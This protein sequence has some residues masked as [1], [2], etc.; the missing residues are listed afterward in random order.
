MVSGFGLACWA[1]LVPLAKQ[2][3]AIGDGAL[4]LLLLC[5]GLGSVGAMQLAGPL[6]SK[7]GARPAILVG[8]IGQAILL[9]FLAFAPTVP[10]MAIALLLFGAFLGVI[11]VGMNVHAVEV[12]KQAGKPLMSGFHGLFSVGGFV[13]S[14]LLTAVLSLRVSP[15]IGAVAASVLMIATLALAAPRLI[16]TPQDRG[17][18]ADRNPARDC[19]AARGARGDHLPD[20]RRDARLGGTVAERQGP[21]AGHAGGARL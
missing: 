9:P 13:G 11:E 5:L 7:L 3:L 8:G 18:S 12:E 6:T 15:I 20:R 10:T 16:L 14:A 1:P 21:V 17:N 19:G 4:G 2:R